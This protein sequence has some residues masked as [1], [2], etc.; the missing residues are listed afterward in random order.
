MDGRNVGYVS[1][2]GDVVASVGGDEI[3]HVASRTRFDGGTRPSVPPNQRSM[4]STAWVITTLA[5]DF[6]SKWRVGGWATNRS[7]TTRVV[8]TLPTTTDRAL[9]TGR[10]LV[11]A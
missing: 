2:D 1:G 3:G 6:P 8:A 11:T 9:P 10:Y 7:H 5:P 4:S